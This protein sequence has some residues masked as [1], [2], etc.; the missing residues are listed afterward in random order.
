MRASS[1][2]AAA[3]TSP[4]ASTPA[5]QLL[6]DELRGLTGDRRRASAPPPPRAR[7]ERRQRQPRRTTARADSTDR[8]HRRDARDRH[9]R[10]PPPATAA[11]TAPDQA[12]NPGDV[13]AV[14]RRRAGCRSTR[15]PAGK[16]AAAP[17]PR[18]AARSTLAAVLESA[19]RGMHLEQAGAGVVV[20]DERAAAAPPCSA[21]GV[22]ERREGHRPERRRQLRELPPTRV[23]D[24]SIVSAAAT[25]TR[26]PLDLDGL[27]G[28][29]AQA[30][31]SHARRT[32]TRGPLSR[33]AGRSSA[34]PSLQAS[35][36]TCRAAPVAT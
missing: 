10:A 8:G 22:R 30:A 4:A 27:D 15:G 34:G 18:R 17:P 20:D 25:P 11:P 9:T 13:R 12:R 7:K 16:R 24:A 3:T 35:T 21:P 32:A 23:A 1:T 6:D 28:H 33:S 19:D 2:R 5:P 29:E 26:L 36:D 14:A 31:R